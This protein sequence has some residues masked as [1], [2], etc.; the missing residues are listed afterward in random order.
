M[1]D[2]SRC[3]L[4]VPWCPSGGRHHYSIRS[5]VSHQQIIPPKPVP[6]TL[7]AIVADR[8]SLHHSRH[9]R[10]PRKPYRRQYSTGLPRF[11]ANDTVFRDHVDVNFRAGLLSYKED[12]G[13]VVWVRDGGGASFHGWEQQFRKCSDDILHTLTYMW[14]ESCSRNLQLLLP[15]RSTA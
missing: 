8:T 15:S 3:G 11:R 12:D 9:V 10:I 14:S 13:R 6:P 7:L 1:T 4:L 2:T 5:L